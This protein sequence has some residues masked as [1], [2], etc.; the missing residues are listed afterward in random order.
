MTESNEITNPKAV[1]EL[2]VLEAELVVIAL[3]P[4][5]VRVGSFDTHLA[6]CSN[7]R[8]RLTI[9]VSLDVKS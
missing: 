8:P 1:V 4:T 3:D 6:Q 7:P 5:V 2:R 9:H